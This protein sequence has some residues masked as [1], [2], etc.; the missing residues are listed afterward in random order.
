M[1]PTIVEE[2]TNE[3]MSSI[4]TNG[5]STVGGSSPS[6]IGTHGYKKHRTTSDYSS[7]LDKIKYSTDLSP[8]TSYYKP[9]LKY[10]FGKKS[11]TDKVCQLCEILVKSGLFNIILSL[12][13]ENGIDKD[14]TPVINSSSKADS[15][16]KPSSSAS[17]ISRLES[18]YSDILDRVHR[19]KEKN[20]EK[21]D[22][23][24]TLEPIDG[25]GAINALAKSATSAIFSSHPKERTPF[26]LS[27][28]P[29]SSTNKSGKTKYDTYDIDYSL[30]AGT[31]AGSSSSNTSSSKRTELGLLSDNTSARL[32]KEQEINKYHD[33]FSSPYSKLKS[34]DSG[35][36]DGIRAGKENNYKSK[37]EDLDMAGKSSRNRPLKTYTR[38]D[39][40]GKKN[41][42]INLFDIDVD[43]RSRK[44]DRAHRNYGHRR[45]PVEVIPKSKTQQFFESEDAFSPV[46]DEE[47]TDREN[48]RKEI[49][50]LIMK[51]AQL[52][53]FY[54]KTTAIPRE[55]R[56]HRP[57]PEEPPI[58]KS[59]NEIA[60]ATKYDINNNT[61]NDLFDVKTPDYF[62]SSLQKSQ[63]TA[64]VSRQMKIM[65]SPTTTHQMQTAIVPITMPG[66]AYHRHRKQPAKPK[67]QFS[68]FVR[69]F[70]PLRFFPI[71]A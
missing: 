66:E 5:S 18:K 58:H 27:T 60:T 6:T 32:K 15:A 42:V 9:I 41:T 53:D 59:T 24:K 71:H 55:T 25:R 20:R 10:T 26:Q 3:I 35:Y 11:D 13:T 48:K 52:D 64:N 21:D 49:Q 44:A 16:V 47:A 65:Q 1:S 30:G 38:N 14:K 23:D 22:R 61:Y 2:D 68:T 54:S 28:H 62:P 57:S 70:C 36:Y 39:S 29:N 19:R 8:V 51:Y 7:I 12:Q 37:Y 45:R 43:D 69:K 17:T 56:D 63:T 33:Y 40:G 4:R 50:G 31:S 46:P 34:N 67:Q